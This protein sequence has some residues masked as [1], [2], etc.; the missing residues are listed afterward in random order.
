MINSSADQP[1][2]YPIYVSPL[3]TS[4]V[5]THPQVQKLTG[6]SITADRIFQNLHSLWVTFRSHI[7]S[8]RSTNMQSFNQVWISTVFF[9]ETSYQF[10]ALWNVSKRSFCFSVLTDSCFFSFSRSQAHCFKNLKYFLLEVVYKTLAYLVSFF[11][12]Y[13]LLY[14]LVSQQNFIL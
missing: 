4:Y 1:I 9:F 10:T 11:L 5:N 3:T 12:L 2:G 6:P 7:G 14:N 13:R 8:N